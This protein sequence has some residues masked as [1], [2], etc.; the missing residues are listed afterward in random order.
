MRFDRWVQRGP[1]TAVDLGLY[2]IIFAVATLFTVPDVQWVGNYPDSL[3]DAPAG[4]F[5]LLSGV[6]APAV[7]VALELLRSVALAVLAVG[8]WTLWASLAVVLFHLGVYL[9]MGIDFSFNVVV[10]GAFVSWSALWRPLRA[11]QHSAVAFAL[12]AA[13]IGGAAWFVT[14][15][16]PAVVAGCGV[17]IVFVGA[18]IGIGYLVRQVTLV[19]RRAVRT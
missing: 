11:P 5:E 9:A 19:S 10:Y 18:A 6:P 16:T 2:R 12:V 7:L 17:V 8:F 15:T 1:L 4:P 3:I 14:S 13:A